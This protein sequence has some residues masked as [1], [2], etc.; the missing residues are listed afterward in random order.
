MIKCMININM[1]DIIKCTNNSNRH[2]D[3]SAKSA[4]KSIRNN[5]SNITNMSNSHSNMFKTE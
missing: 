4:S 2:I 3:T 1:D 5:K